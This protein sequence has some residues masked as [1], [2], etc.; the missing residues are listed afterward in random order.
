[1]NPDEFPEI[2]IENSLELEQKTL[3]E[4]IRKTIFAVSIEE[5]RPIVTCCLFE[6]KDNKKNV[7]A[8]NGFRLGWKKNYLSES[9]N[10]FCAVIP[11]KTLNEVN[12]IISDSFEN[13]K[14]G[15]SKNQT[16]FGKL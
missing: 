13:I 8:V 12:K 6:I 4:M 5:N 3:K 1:M 2:N 7:V 15:V 14:I 16:L 11:E 10:S 9:V